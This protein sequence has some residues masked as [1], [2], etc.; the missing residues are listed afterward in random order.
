MGPKRVASNG[1]DPKGG[2]GLVLESGVT[3]RLFGPGLRALGGGLNDDGDCICLVS[4]ISSFT[5]SYQNVRSILS[6]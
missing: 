3:Y 1:L 4:W 2:C 6:W 5:C